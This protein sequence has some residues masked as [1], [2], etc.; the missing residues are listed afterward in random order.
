MP[1]SVRIRRSPVRAI[2]KRI[3][4]RGGTRGRGDKRAG[5]GED[6]SGDERR[7]W[8]IGNGDRA[9]W[10]RGLFSASHHRIN[11]FSHEQREEKK[12][13]GEGVPR[14]STFELEPDKEA[15]DKSRKS[16]CYHYYYNYNYYLDRAFIILEH[17]SP[18]P[19]RRSLFVSVSSV[20]RSSF[21]SPSIL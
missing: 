5:V 19:L 6:K 18:P 17:L 20:T 13:R 16:S 15:L 2:V 8:A 7:Q 10:P 21:P 12:R 11:T 3:V 14:C 1:V 9:A 4:A